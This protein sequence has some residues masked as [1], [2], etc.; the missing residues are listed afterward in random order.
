MV[1][2]GLGSNLG[3]RQAYLEAA[4]QKIISSGVLSDVLI[5]HLYESNALV[6]E[7]APSDW[8]QPFLNMALRGHT[9][10]SPHELLQTLKQIEKDLGR[11]ARKR[12][13]PRPI[14][15]DILAF[16]SEVIHVD[17]L[18]I[19]HA[20]LLDRPFALCPL[21][22]LIPHWSYPV[23]G[24]FYGQAAAQLCN[25]WENELPFDTRK[26][27][28]FISVPNLYTHT[29]WM[30]ILNIT[31]DSFSDGGC[32][33]TPDQ[34][35]ASAQNLASAGATVLDVGA[36]ST[37]PGATPLSAEQEWARLWPVL[38]ALRDHFAG[39]VKGPRLSVDTRH[40]E[41]AQKC[42]ELGAHII[43]DVTGLDQPH[44]RE[45][46]R[47]CDADVIFMHHSGVPPSRENILPLERDPVELV[48]TWAQQ[49]IEVL[50]AEG[51]SKHRLIFDPGIGFGK[52]AQQSLSLIK[53]ISEF[54]S[55]GVRLLVGHSRKSFLNLFTDKPFSQRDVETA[56]VSSFLVNR[57]VD[58]IRVHSVE[59]SVRATRISQALSP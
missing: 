50:E 7:N 49:R 3:N 42:I 19:P 53:R 36:E 33:T 52:N 43:N 37:R 22:E 10:L 48:Y 44:M 32:F 17:E 8:H 40:P 20:G 55:L 1:V 45:V 27:P 5:S 34:A 46:I 38:T 28:Q 12:W 14:D 26:L 39:F 24:P 54:K 25:R 51:I 16:G 6:P 58:F 35:L 30:G 23:Q 13:A 18:A 41:T 57:Q 59:M 31:P 47:A 11:T 15:I 4:T 56:A 21:A 9:R 2:L 29:Q